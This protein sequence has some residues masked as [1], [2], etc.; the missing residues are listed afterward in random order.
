MR[1]S[2]ADLT[3]DTVIDPARVGPTELHIYLSGTTTAQPEV[4]EVTV[5]LSQP[6][7]GTASIAVKMFRAG[8]AHFQSDG[9]TFPFPG[10][11][12]IT[13]GVR[14]DEFTRDTVDAPIIV[15]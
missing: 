11:W 9:M 8:P 13:I 2:V 10:S 15:R 5:T 7:L 1:G 14:T 3:A 4:E 6:A 12:N